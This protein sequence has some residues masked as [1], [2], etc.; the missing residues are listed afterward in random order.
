[1]RHR[2][3]SSPVATPNGVAWL[4][5]SAPGSAGGGHLRVRHAAEARTRRGDPAPDFAPREEAAGCCHFSRVPFV[6]RVN[7]ATEPG[8][9]A[10]WE[11]SS[12]PSSS[13]WTASSRPRRGGGL[14]AH[15]LDLRHRPRPGDV[16]LQGR[17]LR[18]RGLLLGPAHLRGLRRGLARARGRVRRQVQ[19][20]G[21]VR[22]LHD[23]APNRPGTTPPSSSAWTTSPRSRR[24]TAARCSSPAA[25]T[26]ARRL[27]KAG[28]VDRV[29]PDGLPGRP[30]QRQAA[31]PDRRRG[32][33]EARAA[34]ASATYANGVQL[35]VFDAVR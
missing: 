3:R 4:R 17:G 25:P 8:R 10:P 5:S 33:A 29:E 31:V 9:T 24:A 22:R 26:L 11:P 27:H 16:R 30:R 20:D 7:A 1:M 21:Q 15:R 14:P 32:Q 18:D 35:Q 28:L 34:R 6:G 19:L 23:A 12:S 2:S 13:P